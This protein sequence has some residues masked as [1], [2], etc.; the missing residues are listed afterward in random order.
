MWQ[1]AFSKD[2]EKSLKRL[3]EKLSNLIIQRIKN[4]GDWLDDKKE[5]VVDIRKLHGEWEGFYRLRIGKIRVILSIDE[6]NELINIYGIG[7]R[8]DIYK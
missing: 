4:I 6:E 3:P 8:G 5:L 7:Y 1:F 2:A